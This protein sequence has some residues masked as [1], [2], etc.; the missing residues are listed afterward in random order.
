MTVQVTLRHFAFFLK[1]PQID[2]L[3]LVPET[4]TTLLPLS[5]PSVSHSLSFFTLLSSRSISLDS[6]PY[7]VWDHETC[8]QKVNSSRRLSPSSARPLLSVVLT[9]YRVSVV[10]SCHELLPFL[11]Y[12]SPPSLSTLSLSLSLAWQG[13]RGAQIHSGCRGSRADANRI[14]LTFNIFIFILNIFTDS[15]SMDA[16]LATPSYSTPCAQ[17]P[18]PLDPHL[19]CQIH[20]AWLQTKTVHHPPPCP[21]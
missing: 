3:Q 17:S 11:S 9:V 6:S 19:I 14:V 4:G 20:P 7:P 16:P 21:A 2:K 15:N 1:L 5:L 13:L 12:L 18:V 10:V 8:R